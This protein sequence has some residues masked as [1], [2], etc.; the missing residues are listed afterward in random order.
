VEH[1]TILDSLYRKQTLFYY[2]GSPI[3]TPSRGKNGVISFALGNNLSGKFYS[4]KDTANGGVRKV[5]LIDGFNLNSSYN[6]LADSNNWSG[7]NISYSANIANKLRITG[8]AAY[9]Y[10]AIDSLG[11]RSKYFQW[12]KNKR[13]TRFQNAGISLSSQYASKKK[14]AKDKATA[15]QAEQI[16]NQFQN[17]LDFNVPW[18]IDFRASARL[19]QVYLMRSK[20]DTLQFVADVNFNGDVNLSEN[21]KIT[22]RSGYNFITKQITATDIGLSR[23]LHCWEMSF[24]ITPFGYGRSYIF[25][26]RP[27]S[28]LLRDLNVTRRRSFLDN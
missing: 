18:T 12:D 21:W 24:S 16:N 8:G 23:N 6:L 4:K 14:S 7:L 1:F 9:D 17:Y 19:D 3:G 27:K 10:Y 26:L 28:N 20:K 11:R 2:E 13:L 25:S 15:S 22:Y 5:S